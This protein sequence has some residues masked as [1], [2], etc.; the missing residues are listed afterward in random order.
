[1]DA[2]QATPDGL[3]GLVLTADP[4]ITRVEGVLD[5]RVEW[6]RAGDEVDTF[7]VRTARFDL[8][9]DTMST[10]EMLAEVLA[11]SP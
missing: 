1:M 2:Q 8:V 4:P 7:L 6:F 11:A 3:E 5:P 9:V 10:P